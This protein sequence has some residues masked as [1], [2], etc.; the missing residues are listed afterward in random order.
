[1]AQHLAHI[2]LLV[3]DYD[4]A[5]SFYVSKLGFRLIEDTCIS[6]SKRWVLIAP[7]GSG[8]CNILL[9]KAE[10]SEQL[11]CVGNQSAGRVF[12]F[13]H[14]NDFENDYQN[15]LLNNIKIV[16]QPTNEAYGT[17]LVFSDL[18]GNLWDLIDI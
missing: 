7:P 14:T 17:V 12:L 2:A 16:R 18:Y 10:G 5:L 4:E 8:Q 6:A 9:A 11:K 1:M 3:K 15:L 13:L